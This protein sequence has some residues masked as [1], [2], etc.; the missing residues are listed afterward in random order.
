M[1]R[2]YQNIIRNPW[3]LE[4]FYFECVSE[5]IKKLKIYV[6][7][8]PTYTYIYKID[9]PGDVSFTKNIYKLH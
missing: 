5:I 6:P 8:H 9:E 3:K 4:K 2:G 1:G 7:S